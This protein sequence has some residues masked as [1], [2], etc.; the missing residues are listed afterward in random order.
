MP[1]GD[2]VQ[3]RASDGNVPSRGNRAKASETP[4]VSPER[5]QL[6]RFGRAPGDPG[7]NL[8]KK[9]PVVWAFPKDSDDRAAHYEA[10]RPHDAAP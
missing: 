5:I 6:L 1:V 7:R 10:F 8:V 3:R 4:T 9:G 2:D